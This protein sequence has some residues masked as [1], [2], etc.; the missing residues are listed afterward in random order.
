[1]MKEFCSG[2]KTTNEKGI[3]TACMLYS[4]LFRVIISDLIY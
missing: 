3:A 4:F 1:M 2:Q